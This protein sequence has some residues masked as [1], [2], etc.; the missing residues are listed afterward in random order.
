MLS[1]CKYNKIK[2]LHEL[3]SI[4]WFLDK[5]CIGDAQKSGGPSCCELFKELQ[6]DLEKR[7]QQIEN[8]LSDCS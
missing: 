2:L 3:S 6:A 5:C 8:A 1:D 4:V 7:I